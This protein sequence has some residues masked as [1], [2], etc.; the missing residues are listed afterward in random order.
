MTR[1]V[2]VRFT[3][4]THGHSVLAVGTGSGPSRRTVRSQ[5]YLRACQRLQLSCG[6]PELVSI[7]AQSIIGVARPRSFAAEQLQ[8]RFPFARLQRN[9]ANPILP[10]RRGENQGYLFQGGHYRRL[11]LCDQ[12]EDPCQNLVTTS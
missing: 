9:L 11:D 1:A 5:R 8:R 4:E 6:P 3:R 2:P 10:P 7:I 12:A